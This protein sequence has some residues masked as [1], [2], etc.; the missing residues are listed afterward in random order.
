[1]DLTYTECP[2]KALLPITLAAAL[3]ITI[4]GC[5]QSL[6][7]KL[8]GT[9]IGSGS[10]LQAGQADLVLKEDKTFT[11]G[12]GKG[13]STGKWSLDDRTLILAIETVGGRPKGEVLKE[14]EAEFAKVSPAYRAKMDEVLSRAK[15]LMDQIKL[16]AGDDGNTLTADIKGADLTFTRK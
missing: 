6:E 7:K 3:L 5:Q 4:T 14:L 1:M 15:A 11:L 8:L 12:T 9:W 16:K 13:V 10:G 2:M